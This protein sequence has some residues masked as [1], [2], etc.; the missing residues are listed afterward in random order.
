MYMALSKVPAIPHPDVLRELSAKV[1]DRSESGIVRLRPQQSQ[2]FVPETSSRSTGNDPFEISTSV[3]NAV[4]RERYNDIL[5]KKSVASRPHSSFLP[6]SAPFF[7]SCAPQ[8]SS[9]ASA[10]V[11]GNTE[12]QQLVI[13]NESSIQISGNGRDYHSIFSLAQKPGGSAQLIKKDKEHEEVMLPSCSHTGSSAQVMQK[14][15]A[16]PSPSAMGRSASNGSAN[17]H[18]QRKLPNSASD[19]SRK[20]RVEIAISSALPPPSKLFFGNSLGSTSQLTTTTRDREATTGSSVRSNTLLPS[21]AGH[22]ELTVN[23]VLE[24]I[25][26]PTGISVSQASS[27]TTSQQ[28]TQTVQQIPCVGSLTPASGVLRPPSQ[29]QLPLFSLSSNQPTFSHLPTYQYG[30]SPPWLYNA[31]GFPKASQLSQVQNITQVLPPR[32]GPCAPLRIAEGE[33]VLE[34]LDPLSTTSRSERATSAASATSS[35]LAPISRAEQMEILYSEAPFAESVCIFGLEFPSTSLLQF[36]SRSRCDQMV[37]KCRGDITSALRE[38]KIEHL[39]DTQIASSR[40]RAR[41]ALDSR[42]WDLNAA[43]EWLITSSS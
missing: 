36:Y 31:Y 26:L 21:C 43:A 12:S 39:L 38:L 15:L 28:L 20:K 10:A 41:E 7:D 18:D 23:G 14:A 19:E 35:D 8:R 37:A 1:A 24:P 3:V 40:E 29:T 2:Q 17:S 25:R 5:E 6:T 30:L 27:T 32:L 9:F 4:R 22:S 13:S 11:A 16:S 33:D 34:I 42:S